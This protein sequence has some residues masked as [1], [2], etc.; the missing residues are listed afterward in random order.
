[1]RGI[2]NLFSSKL[3]AQRKIMQYAEFGQRNTQHDD[4]DDTDD[5]MPGFRLT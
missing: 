1:M 5:E 3:D 4:D 2:I